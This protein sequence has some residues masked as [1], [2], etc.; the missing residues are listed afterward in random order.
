MWNSNISRGERL[1]RIWIRKWNKLCQLTNSIPAFHSNYRSILFSF[2]DM[3]TGRTTDDGPTTANSKKLNCRIEAARC[4]VSVINSYYYYYYYYYSYYY[5]YYYY[6]TRPTS[7]YNFPLLSHSVNSNLT[8]TVSSFIVLSFTYSIMLCD[9][10][11]F[12]SSLCFTSYSAI[13][14]ASSVKGCL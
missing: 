3:T 2:R 10:L 5:Y 12:Y 6:W 9:R 13:F 1:R 4:S 8:V 14:A 11:C 7:V